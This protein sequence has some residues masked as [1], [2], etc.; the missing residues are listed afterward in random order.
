MPL[1]ESQIKK[2][3]S[4]VKISKSDI[5]KEE[6][7]LFLKNI[8]NLVLKMKAKYDK[9]ISNLEETNNNLSRKV[10]EEYGASFNELK[11]ASSEETKT[12]IKSLE[13]RLASIKD[14]KDGANGKDADDKII[15]KRLIGQIKIPKIE[16]LKKDL[17][18]MS[19]EIRDAIELL[20]GEERFD[21]GTIRG[22]R[23][24]IRRLEERPLGGKGGGG[25]SYA[26]MDRHIIDPYV[27]SGTVNATNKDFLL[28]RIPNPPESLQ[29]F[30]GGALQSLTEDYT[31]SEKTIS[32]II[33]PVSGE[34]LKVTHRI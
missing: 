4:L 10:K 21:I 28:T 29:V 30:R 7:D 23:S 32:F 27:P 26:A 22:L 34:I 11:T 20:S 14:G 31:L 12:V 33:A 9:E 2:L 5:S 25:F 16:E 6:L 19:T 24:I 1:T 17:P 15:L 8:T 3:E 13:E 18:K